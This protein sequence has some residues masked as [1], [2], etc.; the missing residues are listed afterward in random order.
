MRV[1]VFAVLLLAV[2]LGAAAR[3][4]RFEVR[5]LNRGAA[6]GLVYEP[7]FLRLRPGD[8]VKFLATDRTHNAASVAAMLPPGARPFKGQ[9]DGEIEVRFDVPGR[10]GIR[11]IPHEAMGMVMLVQVGDGSPGAS[12]IPAELP[13]DARDRFEAILS[14]HGLR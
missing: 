1:P 10:Y 3:A 7:D 9:I 13:Q 8:T 2:T 4:E 5:M 12:P 14:R 11:C 6:G